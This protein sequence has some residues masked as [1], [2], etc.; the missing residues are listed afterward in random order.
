M[1]YSCGFLKKLDVLY[2]WIRGGFSRGFEEFLNAEG[3]KVT[4]KAQKRGEKEYKNKKN[5]FKQFISLNLFLGLPFVF[6]L[7]SSALSAQPSR[8]LRSKNVLKPI[9]TT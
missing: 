9:K 5:R 7:P 8:P 6:S 3:A 2:V 1:I 4:Q